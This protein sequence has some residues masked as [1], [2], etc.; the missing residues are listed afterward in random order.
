MISEAV[1]NSQPMDR[2]TAGLRSSASG[3]RMPSMISMMS[4]TVAAGWAS[5]SSVFQRTARS[6]SFTSP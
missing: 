2:R 4:E 6:T 5:R 3:A 1:K